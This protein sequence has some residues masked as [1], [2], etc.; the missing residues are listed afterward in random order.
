MERRVGSASLEWG[1]TAHQHIRHLIDW[2]SARYGGTCELFAEPAARGIMEEL[3]ASSSEEC[4]GVVTVLR[5][6]DQVLAV[7]SSLPRRCQWV[8]YAVW[9][10][11]G[12]RAARGLY[13]R[14]YLER[15]VQTSRRGI[16]TGSE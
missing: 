15:K 8:V 4:G 1:S 13:R 3:S 14:L 5:A 10:I 6:G 11:P 12:E 16:G 2:K 7:S 9:E